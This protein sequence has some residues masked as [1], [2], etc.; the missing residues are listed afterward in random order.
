MHVARDCARAF[1]AE[2]IEAEGGDDEEG[3]PSLSRFPWR[4]SSAPGRRPGAATAGPR[5]VGIPADLAQPGKLHSMALAGSALSE[6]L[7]GY[8][9]ERKCP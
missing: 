7:A 2:I 1:G 9:G 8:L 6:M 4:D 3:T 5:R